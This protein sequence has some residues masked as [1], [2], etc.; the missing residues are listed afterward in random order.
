[1]EMR[2]GGTAGAATESDLLAFGD[3]IAWFHAHLGEVQI[4]SEQTLAMID[5][6]AVPFEVK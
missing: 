5:D 2:P 1:M 3:V 6:D 4:E